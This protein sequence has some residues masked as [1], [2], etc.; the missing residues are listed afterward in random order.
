MW[1]SRTAHRERWVSSWILVITLALGGSSPVLAQSRSEP[2]TLYVEGVPVFAA[3]PQAAV[4]NNQIQLVDRLFLSSGR[5]RSHQP[6][7][8]PAHGD[9]LDV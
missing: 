2:V 4:T 6:P 1:H 5:L 7:D 8:R 3:D 9:R